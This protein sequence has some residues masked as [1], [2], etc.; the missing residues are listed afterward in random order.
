MPTLSDIMKEL[1]KPGR[2]PR[3]MAEVFEFDPNVTS[4]DNLAVG[5]VLPGI[6][7]NIT[8]FGV[9]VDIGIHHDGL[10]HISQLA[11]QYV[12]NPTQIVKLHE[13]IHVRI[14]DVDHKR[15]RIALSLRGMK[16]KY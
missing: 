16:R 2:D 6:V 13:H 1:D 10:I 9:I 4:I 15:K 5:M 7:T 8:N 3:G 11:D 14:I 12:S